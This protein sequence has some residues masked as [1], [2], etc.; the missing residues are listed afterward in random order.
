MITRLSGLVVENER[1]ADLIK[2]SLDLD[3][4]EFGWEVDWG[5]AE[6]VV[7][8]RK[9]AQ[10]SYPFDFAIV[11]YSLGEGQQDGSVVVRELRHQ[12]ADTFILVINSHPLKYPD[13][14]SQSLLAQANH[15]MSKN[16]LLETGG[17]WSLRGVA[18]KI[19][20]HHLAR[21]HG[22]GLKFDFP[23]DVCV[24]SILHDLGT[25]TPVTG[26]GAVERGKRI[27][28][29]LAI[30]CLGTGS[31][32]G[33]TTMT[34]RHLAPGRSGAHV[35]RIDRSCHGEPTESFVLKI[36]LDPMPLR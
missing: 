3:F 26:E 13:Y 23:M 24:A 25:P 17:E 31:S 8:A 10:R 18:D 5:T 35:C 9:A 36:G 34:V 28:R 7:A 29:T 11:D 19:R 12:S 20:R 27:L 2:Q 21:S 14:V 1:S 15:A 30:A 33:E 4:G 22:Y 16:E 6:A 32:S